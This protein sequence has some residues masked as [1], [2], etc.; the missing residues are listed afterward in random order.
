MDSTASYLMVLV[1]AGSPEEARTIARATVE[2]KLAACAQI[3]PIQSVYEWN[4]NIEEDSEHLVL[5]KT[6]RAAYDDLEACVRAHHSYD[7]PEIIAL[8]VVAGH[9]PYLQW[10][11]DIVGARSA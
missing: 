3:F 9:T 10:L 5:L 8:P 7:V 1:A 6:E 2:R 4:G 11:T